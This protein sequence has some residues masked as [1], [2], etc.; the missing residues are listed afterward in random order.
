[1]KILVVGKFPPIEGGVAARTYWLARGLAEHG[2]D[3]TV[4]T[5]A[6]D[7]EP[8]YR[9]W[10]TPE[11][12]AWLAPLVAG[13]LTIRFTA[14][15]SHRTSHIPLSNAGVTKLAGVATELAIEHKPEI[16]YAYYFEPYAVAA[17]LAATFTGTKLAIQHAGSDLS[18]LMGDPDLGR[19][20]KEIARRAD[21][22]IGMER[23]RARYLGMGVSADHLHLNRRYALR[24]EL[25]APEGPELDL[26]RYRD[27]P[28]ARDWPMER[29]DRASPV[30]GIYGKVGQS[31]GTHHLLHSLA[32]LAREQVPFSLLAM[33]GGRALPGFLSLVDQ[34]GLRERTWLLP[35]V[36]HWRVPQF[37][38]YCDVVCFLEHEFPVAIHGPIVP[39]E[40]LAC[41]RCLVLSGEIAAKQ[42]YRGRLRPGENVVTVEDPTDH[43]A[44]AD[45]LRSVLGD[46][47][48]AHRIGQAGRALYVELEEDF[49]AFIRDYEE[50]FAAVSRL[51]ESSGA[52]EASG[53]SCL[54]RL[55]R[56][57]LPN[58]SRALGDDMGSA[59][60]AFLATDGR[61]TAERVLQ[62]GEFV[63][64]QYAAAWELPQREAIIYEIRRSSLQVSDFWERRGLAFPRG[65]RVKLPQD[66]MGRAKLRPELSRYACFE[67]FKTDPRAFPHQGTATPHVFLFHYTS[68]LEGKVY[69]VEESTA[70]LLSACDGQC[71]SLEVARA[72]DCPTD[73]ALDMLIDFWNRGLIGFAPQL[74]AHPASI[75]LPE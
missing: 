58:T 28:A 23:L 73:L 34:L 43:T 55:V 35:F 27:T 36:P 16:I 13:R 11:D 64:E 57:T 42:Y 5:N 51:A 8:E 50:T 71:T 61:I 3:V 22:F 30:V 25:F 46:R 67:R 9:V 4:V 53:D 45:A 1:M 47:T 56:S 31:K 74:S 6:L 68:N 38:R 54:E 29:P 44:L 60:R 49:D 2:H 39:R 21:G 17:W 24:P 10:M 19:T 69:R 15:T 70:A 33:V 37:I 20:Y 48:A 41:G 72:T 32:L 18:R 12:E 14:P 26:I 75:G 40:I 66:R 59:V 65:N 7:V 62:F 52:A 63:L